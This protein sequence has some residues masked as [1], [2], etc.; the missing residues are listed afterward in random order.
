MRGRGGGFR[1]S[2]SYPIW[3]LKL[4][5]YI[6]LAPVPEDS[7]A[8][9]PRS[10]LS[11]TGKTEAGVIPRG[12]GPS[13]Y[14]HERVVGQRLDPVISRSIS[15]DKTPKCRDGERIGKPGMEPLPRCESC[16][17]ARGK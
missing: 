14:L 16:R 2:V 15:V 13:I 1:Y 11:E 12:R 5:L 6:T 9:L 7:H 17:W 10:L 4:S 3:K 8:V